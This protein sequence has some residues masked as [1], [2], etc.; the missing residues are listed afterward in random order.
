MKNVLNYV[1]VI[2]LVVAIT[3]NAEMKLKLSSST[4]GETPQTLIN[5]NLTSNLK[6]ELPA[7]VSAMGDMKDFA[8]GMILL[9]VLADLSLPFGDENEGF[10]H[11]AGT[12]F[13]I[14]AMA[15][16]MITKSFFLALRAG[17]IKFGT[18]T[19]EGSD[20]GF[21][22]K[23]EDSYSQIP[24]LFGA[25]YLFA[26]KGAFKPFI[27]LALGIFL[28]TY[29]VNWQ[30]SGFGYNYNLDDSFSSTG[31]G[32]VPTLGSYLLLSSMMLYASIEYALIFSDL[33]TAGADAWDEQAKYLS[34]VFGVLFPLGN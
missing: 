3:A 9:G 27:G 19:E 11:A 26:T 13:S 15:A 21:D 30:E 23:Y 25:Y 20:G 4:I 17:Y 28:Q 10:K 16:Y 18:Q 12:A 33:P 7:E 29:S 34:V 8:K 1:V 22:Y 6:L 2:I 24:I 31:F 5:N 32:I 14:H